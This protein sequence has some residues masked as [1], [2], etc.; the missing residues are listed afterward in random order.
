MNEKSTDIWS[1]RRLLLGLSGLVLLAVS[2]VG[3]YWV[4]QR[5]IAL[6]LIEQEVRSGL[7]VRWFEHGVSSPSMP[8]SLLTRYSPFTYPTQVSIDYDYVKIDGQKLGAA[9]KH[10][11]GCKELSIGQ[12]S[13]VEI[14]EVLEGIGE[15]P[16]LTHLFVF[17]V[18]LDERSLPVLARFRSLQALSLVP[19]ALSGENFPLLPELR[20][21][22][23]CYSPITDQGLARLLSCPKLEVLLA[24]GNLVTRQGIM[25]AIANASPAVRDVTIRETPFSA[26]EAAQISEEVH[27]LS[28]ALQIAVRR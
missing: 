11:G 23:L 6:E 21:V 3:L 27:K 19:S 2:G 8:S 22:D 9:L 14:Q 28:P 7:R 24:H 17:N 15:Q 26:E 16:S 4:A 5:K 18:E 13:P 25:A 12:G 20:N 1:Q 10:F